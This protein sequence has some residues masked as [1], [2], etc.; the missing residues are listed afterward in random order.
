MM[1]RAAR[2]ITFVVMAL[3]LCGPALAQMGRKPSGPLSVGV[4]TLE[5][6]SVPYKRLLAGRAV[7]YERSEI[8]PRVSGAIEEI[9][10]RPGVPLKA[11]TPMFR[12]E[13]VTYRAAVAS[14]KASVA[15]AAAEL[16]TATATAERY[17]ALQ[18]R[19]ATATDLQNAELAVAKAEAALASAQANLETAEINLEHTVIKSPI[20]GIAA[21]S[22]VTVGTLVTASQAS[23]L[24]TVTRLDPVYVD[25]SDSSAGM[26]RVR[27]RV[28]SGEIL[29]GDK[30]GL[31]LFLE[32][33][34]P[35]DREGEL[36]S[37]SAEVQ[38]STGTVDM[39]IQFDNP[40]RLILPG[41]FLRVETTLGTTKALLV[42]QRATTRG[43]D[44][45]LKAWVVREGKAHRVDIE[46]TGTYNN[47]WV[48][49]AGVA[50]GDV[51]AV[52]GLTNITEGAEVK[53]V[54]V[55]IDPLGVVREIGA[56]KPAA[57]N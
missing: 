23:A 38:S 41:Q 50:E 8:R 22:T 2:A 10:Y 53:A 46:T 15:G 29:P 57:G 1:R 11:G 28:A 3:M 25:V 19:A 14:A 56:D 51:L 33:G 30:I 44:G 34:V 37:T 26:L 27:D 35:Y 18:G 16:A 54:P 13:D 40:E 24:T 31:R 4:V 20:E 6:V 48:T 43:L 9:L 52:D 7:A 5:M 45:S 42:P 21:V 12:I 55:E 49:T 17:R 36:V 32:T 47:A 39:R